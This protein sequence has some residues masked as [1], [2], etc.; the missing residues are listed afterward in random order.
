LPEAPPGRVV[1]GQWRGEDLVVVRVSDRSWEIQCHGGAV[2]VQRIAND[3]TAAGVRWDSG[4]DSVSRSTSGGAPVPPNGDEA[5]LDEVESAVR[6]L[7]P[8]CRTLTTAELVLAQQ[9]NGLRELL[10][11]IEEAERSPK[12]TTSLEA[13]RAARSELSRWLPAAAHLVEP[14]R[15]AVIGPPNAGKSSLVNALAGLERS[16]VSDVP[17]TTRDQLDIEILIDGWI[18]L[19]MDT[20]GIRDAPESA[21]EADGIARARH[22][23]VTAELVLHIADYDAW[24]RMPD[25]GDAGPFGQ[26]STAEF[27]T[28]LIRVV[29]KSDLAPPHQRDSLAASVGHVVSARTG[30]GLDELRAAIRRAVLPELPSIATRL[31]LAGLWSRLNVN[32]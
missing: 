29:T 7:L 19:L 21:I 27:T 4:A 9:S 31:P 15:V 2:A 22:A 30:E 11:D 17:G 25:T 28:P 26:D 24:R 10:L 32:S 16:I 6:A 8:Y 18:F 3:L 23:A 5:R 1:F 20:A 14:W 12:H 13:A